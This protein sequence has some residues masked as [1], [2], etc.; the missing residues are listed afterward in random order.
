MHLQLYGV[1]Q[2]EV[3]VTHDH[4]VQHVHDQAHESAQESHVAH[5]IGRQEHAGG[6]YK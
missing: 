2:D 5:Q 3:H 1:V 6:C 4:H